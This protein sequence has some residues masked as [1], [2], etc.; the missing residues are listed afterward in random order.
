M[1]TIAVRCDGTRD[2]GWAC[3]VTLREGAR[4]ISTHRVRVAGSDVDRL[5]PGADNPTALVQASFEFLLERE[6]PQAILRSF[7]LT[8]IGRY[9]PEYEVDVRRRVRPG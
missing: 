5:A 1:T 4:E 7:D 3:A 6:S 2:E 8:E 9:F